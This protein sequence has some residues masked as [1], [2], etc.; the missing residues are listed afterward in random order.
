[1]RILAFA[2]LA[3]ATAFADVPPIRYPSS[4]KVLVLPDGSRLVS[5]SVPYPLPDGNGYAGG[6]WKFK[7][8]GTPDTSFNGSGFIAIP[9]WGDYERAGN[10]VLQDDGRILLLG[11]A[12]DPTDP[13]L[14]DPRCGY[15]LC[16]YSV[17][18][19]RLLPDGTFDFTFNHSGKA[20]F[21]HPGDD[22]MF[23]EYVDGRI[24][25]RDFY[26]RLG[27][28]RADGTLDAAASPGIVTAPVFDVQAL[29]R[30]AGA[31]PGG[32]SWAI[33][34]QGPGLF[35]AFQ[36]NDGTW[37]VVPSTTREWS[38]TQL[39]HRGPIYRT[40]GRPLAGFAA[41]ADAV[42]LVGVAKFV[43][44]DRGHGEVTSTVDGV[45]EAYPIVRM[46]AAGSGCSWGGSSGSA[47]GSNLT[48]MWSDPLDPGWAVFLAGTELELEARWFTYDANGLPAVLVASVGNLYGDYSGAIFASGKAV[49]SVYIGPGNQDNAGFIIDFTPGSGFPLER[50]DRVIRRLSLTS[51]PTTC[52]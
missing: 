44:T 30:S 36:G 51:L 42:K 33:A 14:R 48:G 52:R 16:G 49:G 21:T 4:A 24:E 3:C 12:V 43:F 19:T 2:F 37:W 5:E 31:S 27:L 50:Q 40:R 39:I 28:V 1:M 38:F 47:F 34:Q 17:T 45:T 41:T 46:A 20:A 23:A 32:P 9:Y 29:W 6:V 35:A 8:D 26:N 7:R 25:L 13:L 11:A 15:G 18:V 22:G 10:I